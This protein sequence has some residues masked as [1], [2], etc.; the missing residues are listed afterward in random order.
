M[1]PIDPGRK[2]VL[3]T[4]GELLQMQ[5]SLLRVKVT[6]HDTGGAYALMESVTL[7]GAGDPLCRADADPGT[8][9]SRA[10]ACCSLNNTKHQIATKQ[11]ITQ[12]RGK[13]DAPS[14]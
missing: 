7:P 6:G 1:M 14:F 3:A 10:E 2:V 12:T 5:G 13:Y 11:R 9:L 8:G 4:E